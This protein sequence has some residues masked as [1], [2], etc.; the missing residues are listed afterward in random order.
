M[1]KCQ[2]IYVE[3]LNEMDKF[4]GQLKGLDFEKVKKLVFDF[5]FLE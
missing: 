5:R 2:E 1:E 3:K 4:N